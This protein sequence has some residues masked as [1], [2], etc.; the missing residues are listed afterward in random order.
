MTTPFKLLFVCMGNICRSPAAHGVMQMRVNEAGLQD[1]VL[2]GL[3]RHGR[4]ACWLTA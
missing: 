4:L 1:Q 3:R 2:I